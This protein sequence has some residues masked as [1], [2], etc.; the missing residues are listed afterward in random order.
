MGKRRHNKKSRSRRRS[1]SSGGS[2][3]LDAI[4]FDQFTGGK[5]ENSS[6]GLREWA[7]SPD[8]AIY[9]TGFNVNH[10]GLSN[11]FKGIRLTLYTTP[12]CGMCAHFETYVRPLLISS[13]QAKYSAALAAAAA[14][15]KTTVP[16]FVEFE[17]KI[18]FNQSQRP[19]NLS[20]GTYVNLPAIFFD[21]VGPN[22]EVKTEER[23]LF[24]PQRDYS[25]EM[26]VVMS[27]AQLVSNAIIQEWGRVNTQYLR[28]YEI[29]KL[30]FGY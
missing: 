11:T 2:F 17:T 27:D 26:T 8:A 15:D 6:D 21:E 16:P 10:N 20:T 4:N 3:D 29:L 9:K 14:S 23:V 28:Q 13:I 30:F 24:Q 19:K 7:S 1:R 25:N 5:S 12:N 18:I 22:G